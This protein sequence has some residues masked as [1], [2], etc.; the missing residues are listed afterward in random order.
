VRD[1]Q[2]NITSWKLNIRLLNSSMESWV[3]QNRHHSGFTDGLTW[4]ILSFYSNILREQELM[5]LSG[6]TILPLGNSG[7]LK[8]MSDYQQKLVSLFF[9]CWD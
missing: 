4:A 3:E 9:E 5:I 8:N 6:S 2:Q 7:G 1:L